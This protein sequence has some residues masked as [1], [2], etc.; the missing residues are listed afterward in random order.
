M[1]VTLLASLSFLAAGC[2]TPVPSQIKTPETLDGPLELIY[3]ED[4]D[5]DDLDSLELVHDGVEEVG[6]IEASGNTLRYFPDHGWFAGAR[7]TASLDGLDS[8]EFTGPA[9]WHLLGESTGD[10]G[11]ETWDP[12]VKS[13]LDGRVFVL[14][15]GN[16]TSCLLERTATGYTARPLGTHATDSYSRGTLNLAD[17][18]SGFVIHQVDTKTELVDLT[19]GAP[20]VLGSKNIRTAAG[21]TLAAH[22]LVARGT[23]GS[24][25]ADPERL[26][27]RT[28]DPA[29]KPGEPL[30]LGP[31]VEVTRGGDMIEVS[32]AANDKKVR[33][34]GFIRWDGTPTVATLH[35]AIT[36]DD[37]TW[38][39]FDVRSGDPN[40]LRNIQVIVADDGWVY[41]TWHEERAGGEQLFSTAYGA[42]DRIVAPARID[43]GASV[44]SRSHETLRSRWGHTAIAWLEKPTAGQLGKVGVRYGRDGMWSE[45]EYSPSSAEPHV[46]L[47][48]DV[49][50]LGNLAF[51]WENG[52][53]TPCGAR[54]TGG[55]W[56]QYC[57][58]PAP[59]FTAPVGSVTVNA[60]GRTY[61]SVYNG[62]AIEIGAFD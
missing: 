59:N 58:L 21:L 51:T 1:R 28:I 54:K 10:C 19:G 17:D 24:E 12:L 46:E 2:T 52:S 5:V 23:D 4:V 6:R 9:K 14:A 60:R 7:Y 8:F 39:I 41:A 42:N 3:T 38:K 56:D 49:D 25:T 27:V 30:V 47:D 22:G 62:R 57:K 35:V 31:E 36:R 13:T 26:V 34:V 33:A 18:G 40:A 15:T 43:G 29:A 37:K 16:R 11:S 61:V 48:M 44:A 45:I 32:A 53:L 55:T 50:A 20:V